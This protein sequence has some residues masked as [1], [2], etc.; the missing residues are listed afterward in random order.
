M[1]FAPFDMVR[2]CKSLDDHGIAEG[3]R[4]VVVQV[5]ETPRLAYE[6]EVTDR[7]GRTVFLGAV[8]PEFLEVPTA[9]E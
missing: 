8:D 1:R 3:T 2:F 6:V 4:G 9:E 7:D 5:H